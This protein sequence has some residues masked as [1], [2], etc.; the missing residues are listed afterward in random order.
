ME[1]LEEQKHRRTNTQ[2]NFRVLD[3]AKEYGV[4]FKFISHHHIEDHIVGNP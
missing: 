3:L 1:R 2:S 4:S